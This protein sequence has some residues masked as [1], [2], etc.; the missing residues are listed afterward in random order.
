ME[1]LNFLKNFNSGISTLNIIK[2][3]KCVNLSVEEIFDK[4]MYDHFIGVTYSISSSFVNTYLKDFKTCDIVIGI[5]ND[6]VKNN[7]NNLAKNFTNNVMKILRGDSIE[8]YKDLD[9]NLKEKLSK[10]E[11]NVYVSNTHIIHSKFYLLWND[12]GDTRLIVGSANLSNTAFNQNSNQFENIL[13]FDNNEL[14][15]FYKSYYENN[16]SKVLTNYISKDLLKL[17]I[18]Q[19]KPIKDKELKN[20]ESIVV[21]DN[22]SINKIK[23]KNIVENIE[24]VREKVVLGVAS[25]NLI[26]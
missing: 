10:K 1:N 26:K 25:E 8:F 2:Y 17:N 21:L 22:D 12:D 7:I 3:N 18:K 20:I 24:D 5:D 6:F 23:E 11:F 4:K 9:I 15:D 16:L 13:I 14:F 19:M